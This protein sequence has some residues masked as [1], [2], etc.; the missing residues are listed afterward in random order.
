MN[1][2]ETA[3]EILELRTAKQ[4]NKDFER[5][6]EPILSKIKKVLNDR[7]IAILANWYAETGVRGQVDGTPSPYK[8][9]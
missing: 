3:K 1:L 5:K 6:V 8:G 4:L 7:E 2:H 9:E